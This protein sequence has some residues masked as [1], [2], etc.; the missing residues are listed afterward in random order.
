MPFHDNNEQNAPV[1]QINS[2]CSDFIEEDKK[3]ENR[4]LTSE[5]EDVIR[6]C[7]LQTSTS[8]AEHVD[9]CNKTCKSG[10]SKVERI[11][12]DDYNAATDSSDE[13][14]KTV[15]YTCPVCRDDV[16]CSDLHGFNRHIDTCLSR[17]LVKECS[18]Y[19]PE[20]HTPKSKKTNRKRTTP[21]HKGTSSKQ[22]K[23]PCNSL[24]TRPQGPGPCKSDERPS[25]SK[26]QDSIHLK[27]DV[28]VVAE[29]E[30]CTGSGTLV[31]PVCFM[32]Q[33]QMDLDAFNK[34]VD[35]CLCKGTITEILKEQKQDN[36]RFVRECKVKSCVTKRK[37]L[38]QQ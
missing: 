4:G 15:W 3:T 29:S 14:S 30:G 33:S 36:K 1:E 26:T 2:F 38:L 19:Q 13:P 9:Y 31:C 10:S 11:S 22:M 32:E 37:I 23:T 16:G 20:E 6:R 35:S 8:E 18:Q 34:H 12:S 21:K 17:S 25:T 27:S 28:D 24:M 7:D 5:V